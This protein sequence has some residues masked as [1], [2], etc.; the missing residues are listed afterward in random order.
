MRIFLFSP[1]MFALVRL[2]KNKILNFF[3]QGIVCALSNSCKLLSVINANNMI[4]EHLLSPSTVCLSYLLLSDGQGNPQ[5]RLEGLRGSLTLLT[6]YDV[7]E[8]PR[9]QAVDGRVASLVPVRPHL[10]PRVRVNLGRVRAL[11]EVKLV[12]DAHATLLEKQGVK[13]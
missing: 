1:M 4:H 3:I 5:E 7:E 12:Q 8:R 11:V 13:V 9:E 10:V 6:L 2:K